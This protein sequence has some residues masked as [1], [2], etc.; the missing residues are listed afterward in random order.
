VIRRGAVRALGIDLTFVDRKSDEMVEVVSAKSAS[1]Q[2]LG[3]M[4]E[5]TCMAEHSISTGRSDPADLAGLSV[6]HANSIVGRPGVSDYTWASRVPRT[7]LEAL[8]V[9]RLQ[10]LL[11]PPQSHQ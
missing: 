8:D 9:P 4:N 7:L 10:R 6:W 1:R 2:V 11:D 3:V 5:F